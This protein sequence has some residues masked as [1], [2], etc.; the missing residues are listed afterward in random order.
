MDPCCS[1]PSCSRVTYISPGVIQQER[2]RAGFPGGLTPSADALRVQLWDNYIV[3]VI[4]SCILNSEEFSGEHLVPLELFDKSLHIPMCLRAQRLLQY[5]HL[6]LPC[7]F[8]IRSTTWLGGLAVKKE[9]LL[10]YCCWNLA[11]SYADSVSSGSNGLE[12]Q[13]SPLTVGTDSIILGRLE[14]THL[15]GGVE[16]S[17]A[18]LDRDTEGVQRL[19]S[20]SCVSCI[21]LIRSYHESAW[22]LRTERTLR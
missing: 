22:Q 3:C 11:T 9:F 20:R 18:Q 13:V 5:I 7:Q 10:C 4:D 8:W 17:W 19:H 1:D 21:A 6:N 16:S 14:T 12:K 2:D 15:G